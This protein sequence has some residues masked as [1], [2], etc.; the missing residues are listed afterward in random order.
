MEPKI[1]S[2]EIEEGLGELNRTIDL[3]TLTRVRNSGGAGSKG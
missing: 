2:K 1:N 3:T